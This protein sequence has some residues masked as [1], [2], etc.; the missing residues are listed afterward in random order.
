MNKTI[1][2]SLGGQNFIIEEEAAD[3]LKN[4]LE[5]IKRHCGKD[6]DA[7]EVISDIETGLAEKLKASLAP[8]KEVITMD[9]IEALIKIMGTSEDFDREVGAVEDESDDKAED[10][11]KISHKLYR[12]VDNAIIGGVAS[13]LGAYFNVDPIIFRFA[14][15]ALC[16]AGGSGV[17]LYIIMWLIT[18]AAVSAH[19]KLEM[20]G[21]APTI[22]AF[23]R[24]AKN[25][26]QFKENWKKR[27]Q[28]RSW[29]GKIISLPFVIL[30]CLLIAVKKIWS[31]LWPVIKFLF[32]LFLILT[33]L[34]V[35]IGA[36]I[37]SFYLFL[38]AQSNYSFN[39]IPVKEL[40]AAI[41][42]AWL[43]ISGF[44]AFALPAL[45]AII[46]GLAIIQKKKLIGL[47]AA[48]IIFALWMIAGIAFTAIGLRYVPEI[49]EKMDNYPSLQTVTDK[50][51]IDSFNNLNVKGEN[52]KIVVEPGAA[53]SSLLLLTGRSVDLERISW[54]QS[55]DDLNISENE[56]D[57][58]YCLNCHTRL[59]TIKV[60]A[61]NL[62][63]L[64]IE[65]ANLTISPDFKQSLKIKANGDSIIGWDEAQ[66]D[67]LSAELSNGADLLVK[68][69][70]ATT[71][72][73]VDNASAHFV[74]FNG[75]SVSLDMKGAD[76][77][78]DWKGQADNFIIRSAKNKS[79]DDASD[80]SVDASALT[81]KKMLINSQGFL[82]IVSGPTTEIQAD[83]SAGSRLF[84]TGKTKIS[85]A[86][87]GQP[88]I[89]Y[90]KI[91]EAEYRAAAE[92]YD[93]DSEIIAA[94]DSC[95]IAGANGK[96]FRL[97]RNQL[98]DELF[99]TMSIDFKHWLEY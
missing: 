42:L 67:G 90:Q 8:Y 85:G 95:L 7:E 96:Y 71:S 31:K 17:A 34:M 27:W 37:S 56:T 75:R 61:P 86:R 70:I 22:A 39:Y 16:F 89:S 58:N 32:A 53:S 72:L 80:G 28:K 76:A 9:D 50:I 29:L 15:L 36:G 19:Q 5:D 52:I 74:D 69:K 92:D 77:R 54:Q 98:S 13:G 63:N 99:K 48:A 41:P 30:N 91:K 62:K 12:D 81:V 38:Q 78:T 73:I 83:L 59:I 14:F 97:N 66:T 68:G 24:L 1:S 44:L 45:L 26:R 10:R 64:D 65:N 84:Y 46:G 82:M 88:I 33:A 94:D 57:K 55:G 11:P 21:E 79:E 49:K 87:D 47:Q 51:E 60:S 4:Y 18:P 3:K 20:K 40:G 35:F 93:G 25:G 6:T 2:I 23:E 43:A